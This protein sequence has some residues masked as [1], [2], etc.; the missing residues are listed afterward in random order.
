MVIL[1][2]QLKKKKAKY[3]KIHTHLKGSTDLIIIIIKYH[4]SALSVRN[5]QWC[6]SKNF[7]EF[8]EKLYFAYCECFGL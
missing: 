8:S 1:Y 3:H 5:I 2:L 6:I 7:L 4:I